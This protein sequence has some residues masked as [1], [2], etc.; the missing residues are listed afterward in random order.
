MQTV[1]Y[2]WLLADTVIAVVVQL[3]LTIPAWP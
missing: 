2:A 1:V 3:G